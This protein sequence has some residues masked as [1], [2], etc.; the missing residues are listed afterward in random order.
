MLHN[1]LENKK[2][3]SDEQHS[4]QFRRFDVDNKALRNAMRKK[5]LF[6]ENAWLHYYNEY[7]YQHKLIT[8]QERNR[9]TN[10]INS[11]KETH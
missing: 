5:E 1:A 4:Q 10:R 7:L 2:Q 8:E 3:Y 9:M 6:A 11:R